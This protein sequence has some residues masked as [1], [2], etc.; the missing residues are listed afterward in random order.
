MSKVGLCLVNAQW[1]SKCANES[2]ILNRRCLYVRRVQVYP[3]HSHSILACVGTRATWEEGVA[4]S[5]LVPVNAVSPDASASR[6]ERA[7]CP[8]QNCSLEI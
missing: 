8:A 3:F 7:E 2:M 6:P 1:L 4:C 5:V